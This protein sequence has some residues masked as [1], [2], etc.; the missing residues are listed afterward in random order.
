MGRSQAALTLP[1]TASS[2]IFTSMRSTPH[3]RSS[4]RRISTS[5]GI[6][7]QFTPPS[8]QKLKADGEKITDRWIGTRPCPDSERHKNRFGHFG[9][10]RRPWLL[11]RFRPVRCSKTPSSCPDRDIAVIRFLWQN[12]GADPGKTAR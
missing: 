8:V 7:L 5:Y 2:P 9:G 1:S 4:S 3:L 11:E 12:G 6:A 10:S